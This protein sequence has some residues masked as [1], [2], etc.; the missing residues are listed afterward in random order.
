MKSA[1]EIR[2]NFLYTSNWPNFKE[3]QRNSGF[4]RTMFIRVV[5]LHWTHNASRYVN[6]K[7]HTIRTRNIGSQFEPYKPIFFLISTIRC[8]VFIIFYRKIYVRFQNVAKAFI[9]ISYIECEFI[10]KN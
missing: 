1:R 10:G 5:T 4:N 3:E 2:E 9:G 8:K 7:F 6:L